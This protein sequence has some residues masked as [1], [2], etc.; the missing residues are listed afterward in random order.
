MNRVLRHWYL[1]ILVF[2]VIFAGFHLWQWH[3]ISS[4]IERMSSVS[5]DATVVRIDK[6]TET[7]GGRKRRRKTTTY[8]RPV[9]EF[10]DSDHIEHVAESLHESSDASLHLR[11]DAVS[12]LYDPRDPES[13]CVIVGEEEAT[14]GEAGGKLAAAIGVLALGGVVCVVGVVTNRAYAKKEKQGEEDGENKVAADD[15]SIEA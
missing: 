1:I 2:A 8:Y 14:K 9:I 6:R 11:G 15:E 3:S 10:E 13:G 7:S 5:D 4:G 12:V